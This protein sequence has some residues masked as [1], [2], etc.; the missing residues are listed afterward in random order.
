MPIFERLN[1]RA[2]SEVAKAFVRDMHA[3]H[4]KKNAIKRDGIAANQLHA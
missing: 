2:D 1:Y 3:F 4:A